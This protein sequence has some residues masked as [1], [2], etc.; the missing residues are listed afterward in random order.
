MP[1]PGFE[2]GKACAHTALDRVP[3]TT[4]TWRRSTAGGIRTLEGLPTGLKPVAVGRLATAAM[5]ADRLEQPSPALEA[6]VLP[7]DNAP[8]TDGERRESDSNARVLADAAVPA[9]SLGQA[10]AIPPQR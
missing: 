1:P 2:P 10:R 8:G 9:R 5:G 4:R 7:L 6:G 3:L